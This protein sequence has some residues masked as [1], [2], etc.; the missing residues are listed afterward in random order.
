MRYIDKCFMDS[1]GC[2]LKGLGL[3]M[4]WIRPQSYYH[5]KVAELQQLQL[6]PHLQGVPVPPGPMERP[7]TLQQQQRSSRRGTTA[8]NTTWNS[9]TRGPMTSEGSGESSW[10]EGGV[11]DDASWDD[12]VTRAEAGPGA[13][14]RK[15]TNA[16]QPASRCPFPLASEEA[17]KGAMGTIYE[18]A[19]GLEPSQR[20][21]ASR[22]ISACYPDFTP[23][24]VKGVASQVLC[25]IA[26]YHLA[27]FT[28]GSTM[29]SPILPEAVEPYLPLLEN[30][31]HPSS[32]G[33]TDVRV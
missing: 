23:A 27:C 25:T 20:N 19:K 8:P 11:G 2:S 26:E 33:L 24:A 32:T 14:K 17:R 4:R 29:M 21:I 31:A 5:W 18:H 7:S 9:R 30:Y 13:S 15:K 3:L 22:A 1:T 6:C 12:L 10:M 28:R 16:G